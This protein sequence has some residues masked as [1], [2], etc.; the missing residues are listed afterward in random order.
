MI[1]N[2]TSSIIME[3]GNLNFTNR[4]DVLIYRYNRSILD[5]NLKHPW[6]SN[7][8]I[9]GTLDMFVRPLSNNGAAYL[10]LPS[11]MRNL[12]FVPSGIEQSY[13]FSINNFIWNDSNF[14]QNLDTY[15]CKLRGFNNFTNIQGHSWLVSLPFFSNGSSPHCNL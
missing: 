2:T 1:A 15:N 14:K 13:Q 11:Q 4:G 8:D 10:Y 6:N 12:V 9:N 3:S 5:E 7:V